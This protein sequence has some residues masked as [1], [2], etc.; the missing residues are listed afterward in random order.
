VTGRALAFSDAEIVK[1]ASEDF[2]P[3]SA[4]DWYQRRRQDSEGEFFRQIA[5]QAGKDGGGQP[6]G[7]STRQGIYCFTADGQLLAYKNAGQA[8]DV[9][10][11]VLKQALARFGKLPEDKRKPGAIKIEDPRNV[12]AAYTRTPPAGG[13]IVNVHARILDKNEQKEWC[14]GTCKALG[15]ELASRDHMWLTAA[16]WK[17]LVPKEPEVGQKFPLPSAIAQRLVRF[18]LIDNTRGEPP[19][20]QAQ[21]VRT[22]ELN[23]TVTEVNANSL[24]MKLEGPVLLANK[25]DA[26]QAERGF[27]A[28]LL[29]YIGYD[30]AKQAID[31]FDV[32]TVG[33]HWGNGANTRDPR[34][35][36]M[37]LGIAFELAAGG[38]PADQIPPQAARDLSYF[39]TGR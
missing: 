26:A 23:L 35:G 19:M 31:R 5:K 2:I 3:V 6:S 15:G 29:G 28:R 21:E 17:S 30:R 34:P 13:L 18:H 14:R 24:V 12:D 9:M 7:G 20:W 8:P 36:R 38:K 16:E 11:D 33:D 22:A 39:K 1:M 32:V 27:D 37:P 10:R 25:A 4:D